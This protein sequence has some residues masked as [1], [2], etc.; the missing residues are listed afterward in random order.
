[1][2]ASGIYL[3]SQ[4]SHLLPSGICPLNIVLAHLIQKYACF[5]RPS[6]ELCFSSPEPYVS[7][8]LVSVH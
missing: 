1:M 8:L 6:I 4:L 3:L 7:M 5:W 2:L